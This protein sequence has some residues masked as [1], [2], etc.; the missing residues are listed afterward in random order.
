MNACK[1]KIYFAPILFGLALRTHCSLIPKVAVFR[2]YKALHHAIL[3]MA[4]K[5]TVQ[6]FGRNYTV[7]VDD[8]VLH[9]YTG[10]GLVIWAVE[11]PAF[12]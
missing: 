1:K 2:I 8:Y 3:T 5:N 9:H 6:P 7:N 10:H 4:C 12:S 11:I